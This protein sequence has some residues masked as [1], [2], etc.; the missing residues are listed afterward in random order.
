MQGLVAPELPIPWNHQGLGYLTQ[1]QIWPKCTSNDLY[2]PCTTQ[3]VLRWL[4]PSAGQSIRVVCQ[5]RFGLCWFGFST[6]ISGQSCFGPLGLSWCNVIHGVQ[7]MKE[8]PDPQSHAQG[9]GKVTGG[10]WLVT[11]KMEEEPSSRH[12]WTPE[13]SRSKQSHSYMPMLSARQ[14]PDHVLLTPKW[15]ATTHSLT[16]ILVDSKSSKLLKSVT[17]TARKCMH[18]K[19]AEVPQ[20]VPK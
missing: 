5:V 12:C 13:G 17:Y 11:M 16:A 8:S 19:R 10:R 14:T 1:V 9:D 3:N 20:F 7:D 6:W 4:H 18:G 15:A 2:T